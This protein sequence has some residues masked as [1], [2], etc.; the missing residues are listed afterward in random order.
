MTDDSV[1]LTRRAV[2]N[3]GNRFRAYE[4]QPVDS[5]VIQRYREIRA[6]TLAPLYNELQEVFSR[7]PS[8]LSCRIKRM[9]TIIRKLRRETRMDLSRMDD[10][11]GFRVVVPSISVQR[12]LVANLQAN[13]PVCRIHDRVDKPKPSGYRGVHVIITHQIQ[14]PGTGQ[15]YGYPVEIQVRTCYQN[16]WSTIS[17]SFGEQ[18]KEGGGTKEE[19]GYLTELSDEIYAWENN[20][21]SEQ[22][23]EELPTTTGL[24][25]VVIL[26][27]KRAGKLFVSESFGQDVT[28]SLRRVMYLEETHRADLRRE[29]VLLLVPP[30]PDRARITH[31]RYY[32]PFGI[33][34][35]PPFLT[36]RMP[37]PG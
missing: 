17:E 1:G 5:L 36:P 15:A 8:V 28:T 27:D 22:Q 31:T 29:T 18:V 2:D 19:R 10:I 7:V 6:L 23:G 4:Q 24:D 33:P 11:V 3:A 30:G 35:I 13:I 37:R 26:F 14:H 32:S 16:L 21:A 34:V 12:R 20:H 9:D 25:C